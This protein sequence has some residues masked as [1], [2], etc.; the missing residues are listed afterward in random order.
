MIAISRKFSG[1]EQ[2]RY[3]GIDLFEAREDGEPLKLVDVHREFAALEAKVQLVPGRL[4]DAIPRIANTHL[5]TDLILVSGGYTKEEINACWDFFPR[6]LCA[7][8]V[9]LLQPPGQLDSSFQTL[10]RIELERI[11]KRSIQKDGRKDTVAA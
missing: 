6:M 8:S 2:I 1:S 5:R 9:L 10:S 7:T 4:N 11:A 3:T